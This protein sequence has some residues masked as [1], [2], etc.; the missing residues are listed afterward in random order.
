MKLF[1]SLDVSKLTLDVYFLTSD[2][3]CLWQS[4]IDNSAAGS[5]LLKEKILSLY[6]DYSFDK[7]VIGME[8]TGHYSLGPSAF[9]TTDEE[10]NELPLEVVVENAKKIHRF[11]DAL[12][13]IK[14]DAIDAE[15]IA[16]F[17]K[18]ERYSVSHARDEKY[19]ALQGLTRTRYQLVNQ[20]KK[21][22]VHYLE[23]LYKKCSALS[24]E[25]KNEGLKT[26]LLSSTMIEIMNGNLSFSQIL[27]MDTEELATLLQTLGR[28]RFSH[29]Q[30][31]A[32][33]IKKSIRDSYRLGKIAQNSVDINLGIHL[34]IIR[35][36]S[37]EIKRVNKAIEDILV[38]IPEAKCLLS[39]PGVGKVYAAG[40]LAE[41]GQIKRFDN[42]AKLA[43]YAGLYWP[44][45]QSGNYTRENTPM[46]GN[47]NRY[48]RYYLVQ[49]TNSVVNYAP[50]YKAYYQK[51]YHEVPKNQHKRALALTARKF[52]RLVDALLRTN[53]FYVARSEA[54]ES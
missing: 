31:L 37:D 26:S 10:L 52:V 25:L 8:A 36:L 21:A 50:E 44:K 15:N 29:P 49:A 54:T 12:T 4:S 14:S 9:F 32:K 42:Q 41:I 22:R 28:G 18:L 20:R 2:S 5:L 33:V 13:D 17:L 1:I 16:Y 34:R 51:K 3:E 23:N 27:E 19:R 24:I 45:K 7:I 11:S 40:I 53:Q 43:R 38:T 47:G 39:I 46:S 6:D 35:H 30:K 48:L